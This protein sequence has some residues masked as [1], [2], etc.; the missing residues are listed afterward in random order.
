MPADAINGHAYHTYQLVRTCVRV[1]GRCIMARRAGVRAG[2][3]RGTSTGRWAP[4]HPSTPQAST[5]LL[6]WTLTNKPSASC[7][8]FVLATCVCVGCLSTLCLSVSTHT[9]VSGD[10]TVMFEF[11]HN[12][13]GRTTYAEGTVDAALFLAGR[14]DA[15]DDK[16]LYNMIDVLRAGAMR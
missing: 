4:S 13:I 2:A 12:V 15:N 10:G 6:P 14:I 9:Q 11:Q 8:V 3:P 1:T 7:I 5:L 16:T